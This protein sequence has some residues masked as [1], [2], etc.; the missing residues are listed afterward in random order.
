MAQ[1]PTI[2][3]EEIAARIAQRLGAERVRVRK[4]TRLRPTAGLTGSYFERLLLDIDG[5]KTRAILKQSGVTFGPPTRE[6]LFFANH[7]ARAPVRAPHCY[8]TGP[9]GDGADP[10][11]VMERLPRGKK[12]PDWT[13]D[14]TRASIRNLARL[15]AAYLGEPP[16]DLP[17]PFTDGLDETLGHVPE[18]V[19]GIRALHE[20]FPHFPR[21][22]TDGALDLLLELVA[23][24][25]IFR[26]AFA[27]S[28][29][30]LLHGDYHRG[31]L[32]LR[33]GD[34]LLAFD[35]QFA[36]VGP[37]AYDLAVFWDYLGAVNRPALFGLIERV[38]ARERCLTWDEVCAEYGAALLELHP[39]ADIDA[40][41]SCGDEAFAWEI[42]RQTTYMAR[43]VTENFGGFL[44]FIYRD[45][46]TIGGW[47]ARWVGIDDGFTMFRQVFAEFE[48]TAER[49][50]A[51]DRASNAPVPGR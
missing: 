8:A 22:M 4:R 15:H 27:R 35:W 39:D 31:N 1:Q 6:A 43:G 10:W 7:A 30:T 32:L 2:A 18:G 19:R 47:F 9:T 26:R 34:P 40:I 44:R 28:P 3:T 13:L 45:H 12:L 50:L 48:A 29:L 33:D 38:E 41:V 23:R 17:R 37:P 24:P 51:R 5:R 21:T 25:A 20:E 36:C 49:L 16:D 14:E 42:V 46:R 11:I